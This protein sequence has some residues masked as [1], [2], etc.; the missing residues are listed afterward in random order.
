MIEAPVWPQDI[1]VSE[2]VTPEIL[3][4][5]TLFVVLVLYDNPGAFQISSYVFS[6]PGKVHKNYY[7]K[8]LGKHAL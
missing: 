7:L 3:N 1:N 5:D 4:V 8:G 2:E 6:T